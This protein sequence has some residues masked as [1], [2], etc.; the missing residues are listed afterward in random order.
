MG[1]QLSEINLPKHIAIIMD[2]NGRWAKK[3]N[4]PRLFGHNEGMKTLR[5]I[6][7][8]SSDAGIKILTVYAFST[9]NWNRSKEEVDGLMKIAVEYF[10]KEV[11]ELNRNNVRIQVIGDIKGLY[12]KVQE[13]ADNA[14]KITQNNTGLIFNVALNY[15]GRDEIVRAVQT[16]ISE[17]VLPEEVTEERIQKALYTKELCDPDILIRTGGENRL[18]NF[19]LWQSAYTEFFF[20]DTYWP[21]FDKK[22]YYQLIN[23]YQQRDRRFGKA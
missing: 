11:T 18:S 8:A 23:D 16:L 14:M 7:K 21:D 1:E 13:A 9:E 4:R 12:P 3:K 22:A 20:I 6:V 5:K 15:G 17:G 10:K 19:M 2:G